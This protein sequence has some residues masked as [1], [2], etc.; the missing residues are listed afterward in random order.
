MTAVSLCCSLIMTY[1]LLVLMDYPNPQPSHSMK[2]FEM[3]PFIL[4]DFVDELNSICYTRDLVM[5]LLQYILSR[6]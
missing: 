4:L 2:S 3:T 1:Q 5:S 6:L